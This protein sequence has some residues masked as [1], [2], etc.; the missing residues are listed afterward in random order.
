LPYAS[1]LTLDAY[2]R[3]GAVGAV[4]QWIERRFPNQIAQISSF[5]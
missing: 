1:S 5:S 4:A 2:G 3:I